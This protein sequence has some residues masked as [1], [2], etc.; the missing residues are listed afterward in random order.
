MATQ[1]WHPPNHGSFASNHPGKKPGETITLLGLEQ[2]LWPDHCVQG[3][4]GAQFHHKLDLSN[5]SR[6]FQ[7]GTNSDI[8]SYSGFFDNGHLQ[9]TGME[10]YL[11]QTGVS[12]VSLVGLATDYCV[13][14]TAL[15]AFELGFNTSV[16]TDGTRA[17]N[18]DPSDYD[19]AVQEMKHKGIKISRSADIV[20]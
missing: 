15:D 6:V 13:K 4:R 5:V 20:R 12:G 10:D 19:R 17:V 18:L 14:F 7:K 8:D 11:R 2:I 3:T 16:I 9:A 1:D